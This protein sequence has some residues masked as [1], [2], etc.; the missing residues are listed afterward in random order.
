MQ[1]ALPGLF[2]AAGH[3]GLRL[4]SRDGL[5][6]EHVQTGREGETYRTVCFGG[7]MCLAVGLFGGSNLFSMSRDGVNWKTYT[8]DARYAKYLLSVIY[9][10][11]EFLGTGGDPGAVGA[12][13][14]FIMSSKDGE[15]WTEM[16][17]I[18]GRNVLRRMAW[19]KDRLVAVGDR[20]RRAT[21]TDGASWQDAMNVKATDTLVDIAFGAGIFVGVGLHGLRM[22]SPDGL[23][24]DRRFPGEEGE[25]L[26]SVLWTGDRFVAVGMGAT[27]FSPNGLTWERKANQN[28]PLAATFGHGVFLGCAWKGRLLRSTDAVKWEQVFK[29]DQHIEAVSYGTL[30]G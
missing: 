15:N 19:G 29:A 30:A 26:N 10:R 12:S 6:W 20:G 4:V 22:A 27:Y 24:W 9:S 23:T 21:S 8:R 16:R 25:H 13:Q 5:K 14:P 3:D 28:A 17:G 7:G 1:N 18:E 2:A 11:G